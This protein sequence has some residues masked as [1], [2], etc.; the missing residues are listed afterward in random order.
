M[1]AASKPRAPKNESKSDAV[2]ASM[3]AF[4][5]E[6]LTF[7]DIYGGDIWCDV[8]GSIKYTKNG[9]WAVPPADVVRAVRAQIGQLR[10]AREQMG[11]ANPDGLRKMF[12]R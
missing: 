12:A 11:L 5:C 7:R 8:N 4:H 6:H 1:N 10:K 3:G 2:I 9:Q